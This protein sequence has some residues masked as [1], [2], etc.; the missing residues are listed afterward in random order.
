[1]QF[2]FTKRAREHYE[3]WP[4]AD[5][6]VLDKI[7]QLLE[8]IEQ[9]PFNVIGKPEPLKYELKGFW[10]R[11]ITREHRLVYKISGR[12]NSEQICTVIQCRFHY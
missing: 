11:R 12:M 5:P 1:M 10:S 9:S 2:K 7:H 6:A 3:Y 4:S 8:S